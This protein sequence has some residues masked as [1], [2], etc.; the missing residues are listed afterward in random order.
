LL[1]DDINRPLAAQSNN[2]KINIIEHDYK[3]DYYF[4]NIDTFIKDNCYICDQALKPWDL[5]IKQRLFHTKVALQ[6]DYEEVLFHLECFAKNSK[7]ELFGVNV[8]KIPGF[9]KFSDDQTQII[10]TSFQ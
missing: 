7:T 5:T 2:T 4:N 10:R 3:I 1:T 6:Y 9:S 8:A